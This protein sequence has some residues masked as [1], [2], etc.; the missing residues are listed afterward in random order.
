MIV[1]RYTCAAFFS[2]V[3]NLLKVCL[4]VNGTETYSERVLEDGD[5]VDKE[6]LNELKD[7]NILIKEDKEEEIGNQEHD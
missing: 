3:D 1:H 6:I 2:D 5:D 4:N 7:L